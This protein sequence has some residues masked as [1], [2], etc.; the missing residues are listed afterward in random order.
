MLT[1]KLTKQKNSPVLAKQTSISI[2]LLQLKKA[3]GARGPL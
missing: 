2:C 3:R 1:K